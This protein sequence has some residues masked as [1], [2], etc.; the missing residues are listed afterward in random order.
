MSAVNATGPSATAAVVQLIWDVPLAP[1]VL[2]GSVSVTGIV[3][4]SW[5]DNSGNETGFIVERSD[6]NQNNFQIIQTT[7][8]NVTTFSETILA[9][10]DYYYRVRAVNSFGSSAS[11]QV[12][13]SKM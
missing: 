3:S 7:A 12:A 1:T 4:L 9:G 11:T 13:D 5:T 6:L 8:A 2:M 10:K